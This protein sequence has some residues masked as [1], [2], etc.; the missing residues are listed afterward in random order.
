MTEQ[1]FEKLWKENREK[2]LANDSEYQR[3]ARSY[4]GWGWID[5]L[6]FIGGFVI[7]ENFTQTLFKS[8]V[9][10]YLLAIVGMVVVWIGYRFIK[11]LTGGKQTLESVEKEIKER[12]KKTLHFNFSEKK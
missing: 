4:S 11:S 2:I 1:E 9:L 7:C 6:V 5:Y 3:I 8:I 12:Y 10:Q